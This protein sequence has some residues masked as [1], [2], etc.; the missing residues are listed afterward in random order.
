LKTQ[1][2]KIISVF[3]YCNF[4]I[5]GCAASLVY[6]TSFLLRL[7]PI[8]H[9]FA[10]LVF[11]STLNIYS[12]HYYRKSLK[13]EN[14]ERL[15]W[16]R[17]YKYII[18]ALLLS[19]SIAVVILVINHWRILFSEKN[20]P[21]T[22]AIPLLSLA[23]SFPFL[24]GNKA[25]RHIGWL[26]LPLL[27]IVWSFTA[28]WLPVFYSGNAFK[29]SQVL[30]V[31]F[32]WLFFIM[33]LC[34]LFNVRDYKE[35]KKENIITP[36]VSLGPTFILKTG[37]WLICKLNLVMFIW[38]IFTFNFFNPIQILAVFLPVVFLFYLFE[39]FRFDRSEMQF[40]F[41]HDG[42]MPIKALLLIF[43]A[44]LNAQ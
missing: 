9:W 4:F 10:A 25:L 20:L 27:S 11:C 24:P 1:V 42:L 41:L 37:K 7:S 36:A 21:W 33:A 32:D 29:T 31:F 12:F 5:A 3:F 40:V 35:D 6:S 15:N 38:L 22:L 8:P 30:V 16:Y 23:Y 2:S 34:M 13:T 14:D 39:S 43:A 19:G 18:Q 44:L 17:K 28:V 26:K